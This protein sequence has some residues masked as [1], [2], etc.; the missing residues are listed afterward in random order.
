MGGNPAQ[1]AASLQESGLRSITPPAP[2]AHAART[3]PD[4]DLEVG[5]SLDEGPAN[6]GICDAQAKPGADLRGE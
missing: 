1:A 6:R 5:L 3:I 4:S 2:P